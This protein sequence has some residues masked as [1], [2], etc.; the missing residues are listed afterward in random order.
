MRKCFPNT[1]INGC[2][3][4]FSQCLWRKIQNLGLQCWYT[5]N[6]NAIIIKQIQALAFVPPED[7]AD[8][9]TNFLIS[10]D[11]ETD[12]ILSD[13]FE[14]FEIT[15][16]GIV[17]R[18]RRRRPTFDIQMWNVYDRIGSDLPRTTNS[19]EGWH[20]T[21]NKRVSITHPTFSKLVKKIKDEQASTEF[22]LEQSAL[23]ANIEQINKKYIQINER[24][25]KI[26]ATYN[27]DE[28][29]SYLRA[30]AHNF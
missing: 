16:L 1:S 15:W 8:L 27:K 2:L 12:E 19:L 7:V 24:I 23:G 30:I 17:Q 18:G 20:Q 25:R 9:F 4:H 21:F 3:F 28:G 11:P 10:I 26:H 14:Y 6:D 29:L 5:N 13:F 22:I